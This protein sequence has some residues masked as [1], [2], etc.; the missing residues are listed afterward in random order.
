MKDLKFLPGFL[1]KIK[2]SE[3]TCTRRPIKPQPLEYIQHE[4]G[5]VARVIGY[6]NRGNSPNDWKWEVETPWG[7]EIW[8]DGPECQYGK[9][10]DTHI[11]ENGTEIIIKDVRV[12]LV[13][14]ISPEECLNEGTNGLTEFLIIWDSIYKKRGYGW[15]ENPLVWVID[16]EVVK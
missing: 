8:E 5:F 7:S 3:K 14:D 13:H 1:P 2:S 12:E 10:G 9:P 16:F 15:E 4:R 11:L 6:I